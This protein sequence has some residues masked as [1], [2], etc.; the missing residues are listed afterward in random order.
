MA[1]TTSTATKLPSWLLLSKEDIIKSSEW[2]DLT[3]DLFDAVQQQLMESHVSYFSDLTDSEKIMFLDRAAKLVRDGSTYKNLVERV[4]GV[5]D[6]NLNEEVSKTLINPSNKYTKTQLLLE[7]ASN[8]SIKLLQRWPDLRTKLYSCFNR[9]LPNSLRE[10]VWKM[11]LANPLVRQDYLEKVSRAK[12]DTDSVQDAAIG[13]KCQAFLSSEPTFSEIASHPA[14]IDVMKSALSYRQVVTKNASS[15][16][17][18][19][20]LLAL[21]FLKVLISD[22]NGYQVDSEEIASFIEFYFTFMD[23]RPPLMKDSKSK[24]YDLWPYNP[25]Y[26]TQVNSASCAF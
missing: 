5:L 16:V 19:D 15:I 13:Q 9:P 2:K 11:C 25:L 14:V 8:T 12:R 4:S 23:S 1:S 22:K 24:V 20:Y 7:G 26:S 21:P 6:R 3:S 17:D 18:T 10:A